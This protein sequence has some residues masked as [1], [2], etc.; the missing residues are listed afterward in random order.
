[1]LG[2]HRQRRL[3]HRLI[4]TPTQKIVYFIMRTGVRR[5]FCLHLPYQNLYLINYCYESRMVLF[6]LSYA[7]VYLLIF[8]QISILTNRVT[9]LFTRAML[10]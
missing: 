2:Q 10:G 8:V 6:S 5:L 4:C 7:F 3:Y 9:V 1:M